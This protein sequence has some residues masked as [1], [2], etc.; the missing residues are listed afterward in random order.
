MFLFVFWSKDMPWAGAA[1]QTGRVSFKCRTRSTPQPH[2]T[3]QLQLG[4]SERPVSA[5]VKQIQP[6][7]VVRLVGRNIRLSSSIVSPAFQRQVF[8]NILVDLSLQA[9]PLSSNIILEFSSTCQERFGSVRWIVTWTISLHKRQL[10]RM[11]TD[12]TG[13]A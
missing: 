10:L 1:N 6:W 2:R 11:K 12:S 3:M 9:Q 13:Q 8:A 4:L 5:V 7:L